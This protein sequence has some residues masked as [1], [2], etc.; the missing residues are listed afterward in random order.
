MPEDLPIV[1]LV[2]AAGVSPLA[3]GIV[4]SH[5]GRGAV[6]A[7]ALMLLSLTGFVVGAGWFT[8][9]SGHGPPPLRGLPR[10]V[11]EDE[12]VGSDACRSCHPYEHATWHASYHR[13]MTQVAT[14]ESIL[15]PFDGTELNLEGV[16]WHVQ[17]RGDEFWVNG[18][19]QVTAVEWRV[20][21][22][23][24]SH[25]YQLYWL[26]SEGDA[27]LAQ[28]PLVYLLKDRMW[29]PRKA[30]FLQPPVER[31][32]IET[33]RW[34]MHCIKCHAT[35]GRKED[36]PSGETRVAELGITCEACHGPGGQHVS[37]N[38]SP[39]RRYRHHLG[40]EADPT[41]VNPRRLPHDRATEVCGQCHGIEIFL[42]NAKATDWHHEGSHY[43]PGD[44]LAE[45]QTTVVGR[46]DDNPPPVRRYLDNHETFRLEYCFWSDGALRVTG[47]E[48]HGMLETPCYQRG[49]MSC[50]SCH[51]LHRSKEDARPFSSWAEDQL[52]PGMDGDGACLQC[53]DRF[54]DPKVAVAHSHHA[55]D[56][57]GTTCYN[58]HMP[59]TTWGLLGAI[60]SHTVGS[61]N[62]A[63]SL[64]TGRPN[65]C[66]QCHLDQTLAWTA[67]KLE[68]WYDIRPPELSEDEKNT[69]ASAIWTLSGDAGQRALMA[70][71]MGWEPARQISGTDW[72]V[73]YLTA[74]LMDPY[75]A[76]RYNAQR[77]L[78]RYPEYQDMTAD[79]VIGATKHDHLRMASEILADWKTKFPNSAASKEPRLLIRPDGTIAQDRFRHFAARRD[80]R[81]LVLFE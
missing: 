68:E 51:A 22:A 73:P 69:A 14:P 10:V 38:R 50:L 21:M 61:P 2:L 45:F 60:R 72:M 77:T 47:R 58:C 12:Y 9:R 4:R 49:E 3:V 31:T 25:N 20:A 56:S 27:G 24:G 7:V 13:T 75:H 11:N 17:R 53:H 41:I 80:N 57:T 6:A 71:S 55:A 54:E 42:D 81:P 63:T 16:T 43:R 52:G 64:G 39:L 67:K 29:I 78:H 79:T 65:A 62:V 74:L 23:T 8:S 66:N 46:Y 44:R 5:R 40:D 48:Y 59:Y 34:K 37:A 33:G 28:F 32:P 35:H 36:L 76:V 30:R 18:K 26:E 1:F 19:D 70:W 15:A